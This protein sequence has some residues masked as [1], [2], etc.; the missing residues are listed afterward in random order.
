MTAEGN[1]PNRF[2]LSLPVCDR[3]AWDSFHRVKCMIYDQQRSNM[4]TSLWLTCC[5]RVSCHVTSV[6]PHV[7]PHDSLLIPPG[8][9]SFLP[10]FPSPHSVFCFHLPS[11]SL[12]ALALLALFFCLTIFLFLPSI[13]LTPL[14]LVEWHIGVKKCCQLALQWRL[15]AWQSS[16]SSCEKSERMNKKTSMEKQEV[17]IIKELL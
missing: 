5:H 15:T 16:S 11:S 7:C 3:A 8:H 12:C 10:T 9:L 2:I 6:G 14:S 4:H 17:E 13:F 1:T